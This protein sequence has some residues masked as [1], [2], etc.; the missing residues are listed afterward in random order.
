MANDYWLM[1]VFRQ[2]T[3]K[4][5]TKTIFI[6]QTLLEFDLKHGKIIKKNPVLFLK[7]RLCRKHFLIYLLF[8]NNCSLTVV[9]CELYRNVT[10]VD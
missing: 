6:R 5:F 1:G 8:V 2:F 4:F 7:T 10:F 3:L 9:H